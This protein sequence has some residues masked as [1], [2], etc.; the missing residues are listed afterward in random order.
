MS[1]GRLVVG[2]APLGDLLGLMLIPMAGAL[3]QYTPSAGTA[4]YIKSR[5]AD[6]PTASADPC[7]L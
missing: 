3:D 4:G 6:V 2:G 7:D 1:C 5:A